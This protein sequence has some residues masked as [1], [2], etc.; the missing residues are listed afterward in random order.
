MSKFRKAVS[1]AFTAA[2]AVL[3]TGL[4]TEIP[5]TNAGW[6]ALLGSAAGAACVAGYAVYRVPNEPAATP[7]VTTRT[8]PSPY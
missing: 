6:A 5:R 1:A 4:A 8:G 7:T 2:L 3:L